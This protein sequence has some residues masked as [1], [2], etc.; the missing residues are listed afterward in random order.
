M[1]MERLLG[2]FC[3]IASVVACS[4]RFEVQG[5]FEQAQK[6][7]AVEICLPL[8]KHDSLLFSESLDANGSFRFSKEIAPGTMLLVKLPKDYISIP[9]Y[10]E[11]QLYRLLEEDGACYFITDN[12]ASWQNRYVAFQ[13]ELRRLESDYNEL[14]RGYDTIS[15]I[16]AK[17]RKSEI[18][19][20]KFREKDDYIL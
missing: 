17:A 2:I 11:K 9:L 5:R 1:V 19:N 20:R 14:W 15:D 4:P 10:V 8:A 18:I 3:L 7:K 12:D 6:S 16:L 13:K